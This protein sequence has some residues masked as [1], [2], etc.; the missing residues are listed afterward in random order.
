MVMS[1]D[2]YRERITAAV[3]PAS[4]LLILKQPKARKATNCG[5]R[6]PRFYHFN[7]KPPTKDVHFAWYDR[8]TDTYTVCLTNRLD[9]P[10]IPISILTRSKA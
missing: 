7:T 4:L 10:T 5:K 9:K 8:Y 6:S 1:A 2:D 3:P